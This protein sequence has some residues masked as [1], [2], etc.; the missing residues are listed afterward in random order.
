MDTNLAEA[1]GEIQR[2]LGNIEGS[3]KGMKEAFE[4]HVS[5]DNE[6][7]VRVRDVEVALAK[8][9]GAA[10]VWNMVGTASGVVVGAVAAYFGAKHV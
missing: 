3:V 5:D 9:R 8:Q 1:L 10:R 2:S 7:E 4:R 6:V